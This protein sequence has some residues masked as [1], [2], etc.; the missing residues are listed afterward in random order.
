VIIVIL[1]HLIFMKE[2]NWRIVAQMIMPV[3][4]AKRP[5]AERSLL[6]AT[7]TK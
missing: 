1:M 2:E 7:L 5:F 3:E 6:C 4:E